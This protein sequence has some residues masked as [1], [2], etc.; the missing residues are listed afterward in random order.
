MADS[1][2]R[3]RVERLMRGE[4]RNDDIMNLFLFARDHC[5]GR[6]SVKEIGNF[7][8]HHSE[9]YRGII[10]E[11]TRDWFAIVRF[12]TVTLTN[13][14]AVNPLQLPSVTPRYLS[15]TLDRLSTDELRDRCGL[16]RKEAH[17]LLPVFLGKLTKKRDGTYAADQHYTVNEA[18]LFTGLCGVI[19]AR[20][21]FDGEKLFTDLSATLKSNGLLLKTELSAFEALKPAFELFAVATMHNCRIEIEA[22]LAVELKASSN[23]LSG[24]TV[25]AAVP[26]IENDKILISTAMFV[27]NLPPAENCDPDLLDMQEWN[28]DIELT[29]KGRL[30]ILR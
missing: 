14:G 26:T 15:A 5:D 28:T 9:R 22:G 12:S 1:K 29:P 10:T 24:I 27:T 4:I 2:S 20:P 18:N 17:K 16:T 13:V 7:V 23:G 21:A 11:T 25:N 6:E 3:N 8:A 19:V 30:G